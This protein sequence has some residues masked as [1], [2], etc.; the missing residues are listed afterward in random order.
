MIYCSECGNDA[1]NGRCDPVAIKAMEGP[2][3]PFLK[4]LLATRET[5][6]PGDSG[7]MSASDVMIN[8]NIPPASL[9][10]QQQRV[11]DATGLL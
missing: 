1:H 5:R 10:L 7:Y 9:T 8:R 11:D 2:L 6:P 3:G 4:M